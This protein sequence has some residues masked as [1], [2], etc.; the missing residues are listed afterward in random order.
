LGVAAGANNVFAVL[1]KS[2]LLEQFPNDHITDPDDASKTLD[3]PHYYATMDAKI[4]CYWH[5]ISSGGGSVKKENDMKYYNVLPK[6]KVIN[7]GRATDY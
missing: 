4:T 5:S 7:I 6:L 1:G 2:T 3:R